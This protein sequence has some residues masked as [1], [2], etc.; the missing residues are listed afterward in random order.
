LARVLVTKL[1]RAKAHV[2]PWADI[3]LNLVAPVYC[4]ALLGNFGTKE[5]R[6]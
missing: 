4:L 2:G 6:I 1:K 3:V 5:G